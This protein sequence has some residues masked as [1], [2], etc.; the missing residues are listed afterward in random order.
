MYATRSILVIASPSYGDAFSIASSSPSLRESSV[1][2]KV[3]QK[4][5]KDKIY[6]DRLIG[7][8]SWTY[9]AA[10]HGKVPEV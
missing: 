8:Y 7:E 4:E 9:G 3:Q 1:V 10:R 5:I 6:F 2:I